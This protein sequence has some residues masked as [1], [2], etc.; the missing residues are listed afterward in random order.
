MFECQCEDTHALSFEVQP[1][2]PALPLVHSNKDNEIPWS[3]QLIGQWCV[4]TYEEIIY[5]GT[6]QEITETHV[7]VKCMS[8]VGRAENRFFWSLRDDVLWYLFEDVLRIIPPPKPVNSRHVEI[9]QDIWS[10]LSK[11]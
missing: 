7:Q 3:P 8:K 4:V 10:N 6:I 11:I 2:T 9:N 5:P 1:S